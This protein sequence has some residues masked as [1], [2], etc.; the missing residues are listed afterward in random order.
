VTRPVQDQFSG[1]RSGTVIDP[2]GHSW[3]I[4]THVEDVSAEEMERRIQ[5]MTGPDAAG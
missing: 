1:D 2:F 4:A 3:M 5:G